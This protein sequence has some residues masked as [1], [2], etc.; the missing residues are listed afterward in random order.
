MINIALVGCGGMAH[1]HANQLLKI[2]EC[3]VV[4]TCDVIE[5][6]ALDYKTRYFPDARTF[7]SFD[8]M[9]K[10]S[11]L[12]LDAVVLVTPHTTHY[13]Q[14][15][16]ALR[17]GLHVCVEK[18]MVTSSQHAYDLWKTVNASGKKLAIALQA[19][20]CAEY[21]YIRQLRDSGRLGK[22]QI[23][24]GWLAQ[25]WLKAV[26]GTW[27]QD[28]AQS[29]GGQMYDSGAHVLNGMMWLMNEPVVEVACMI[30]N[31]G[32]PVDIN[33]VAIMK[34]A[35]GAFGSVAIGGNSP[36]WEVHIKIQTD[37][38]QVVTGPHGG[39]LNIHGD[40]ELKYPPVNTTGPSG[41]FTVNR[42]FINA[43]LGKE[44][45][46]N[47][48]RYGVLLSALMDAMYESASSGKPVK[49]APVPDKL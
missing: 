41:A 7:V 27:R 9:I 20:Y 19:P 47:P 17:A 14:A 36:G 39:F 33:G 44:E 46:V 10:T 4:A 34:F 26:A 13:P 12:K 31:V 42:N 35:S 11:D 22:V 38:L 8:E 30:D 23:I 5:S 1:S 28:P 2:P 25:G 24:Q 32:C 37:R 43:I 40:P 21:Q 48:V 3:K 49:V 18:P 29:G 15:T 6:R 16:A 45:L